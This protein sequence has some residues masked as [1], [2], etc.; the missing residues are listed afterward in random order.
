MRRPFH[1][2]AN[3]TFPTTKTCLQQSLKRLGIYERMRSSWIYDAYWSLAD[4]RIIEDRRSELDFYRKL[5]VGFR[6]GDLIF[7][8]GANQGYK[9]DIFLRLGAKVLAV[10]P[11]R[12]CQR[13]LREKFLQCRL[14]SKP[15]VIAG[16]AVSD[17]GSIAT[18][19]IDTPGSAKNTLSQK[20][21]ETLRGDG[22]RFGQTLAF[23]HRKEIQTVT[24][25]QLFGVYGSPF[26][27]KI[28]VEGHELSVLRGMRQR[29]P[30][31]SFEVNLPEFREEG[32]ECLRVLG[33][34]AERGEFNYSPDC[35]RGLALNQWRSAEKF[36]PF[37][38]SCSY[39]SVEVFWKTGS[40]GR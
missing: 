20:W 3:M 25:E 7:D 13:V 27:V 38:E 23:E 11:D 34:L 10:E 16:E 40:G 31:L 6:E 4:R 28:D 18:M 32:L 1:T 14:R 24:M 8:I 9:T 5:L 36:S 19:W 33:S 29:V 39:P 37:L 22:T 15:L 26:F 30:Y 12:S 2:A 35:R 21:A 17:G